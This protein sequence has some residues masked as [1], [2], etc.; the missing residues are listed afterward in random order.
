MG[1][2]GGRQQRGDRERERERERERGVTVC[3]SKLLMEANDIHI[4]PSPA[5]CCLLNSHGHLTCRA[6]YT[7]FYTLHNFTL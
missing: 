3:E 6:L 2:G 4:S 5:V 1:V 7:V